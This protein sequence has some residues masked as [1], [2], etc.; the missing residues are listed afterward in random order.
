MV[1]LQAEN[2]FEALRCKGK[3]IWQ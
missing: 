2:E 3:L 1:V